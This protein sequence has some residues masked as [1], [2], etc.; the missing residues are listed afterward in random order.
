MNKTTMNLNEQAAKA[1]GDGGVVIKF[2]DIR[3]RKRAWEIWYKNIPWLES[4]ALRFHPTSE[5]HKELQGKI[6]RQW[7]LLIEELKK[8]MDH[9]RDGWEASKGVSL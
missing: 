8:P 4:E 6:E 2:W 3:L 1:M 5:R 7:E 9:L